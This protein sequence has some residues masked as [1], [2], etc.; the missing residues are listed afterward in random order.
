MKNISEI[1]L[2]TPMLVGIFPGIVKA[3]G[4]IQ[5]HYLL[6]I[7]STLMEVPLLGLKKDQGTTLIECTEVKFNGFNWEKWSVYS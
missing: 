2:M 4:I 1:L 3:I 7:L 5:E 6:L